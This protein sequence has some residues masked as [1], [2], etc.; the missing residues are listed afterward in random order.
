MVSNSVKTFKMV[1][2]KT[3]FKIKKNVGPGVLGI[4]QELVSHAESQAIGSS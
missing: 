1:H 2:I 3:I 4:S